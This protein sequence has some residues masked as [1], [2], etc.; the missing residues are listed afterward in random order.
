MAHHTAQT[1]YLWPLAAAAAT[2][3]LAGYFHSRALKLIDIDGPIEFIQNWQTRTELAASAGFSWVVACIAG[4]SGSS[5]LGVLT[6]G[7]L[8]SAA[9]IVIRAVRRSYD[10][11]RTVQAKSARVDH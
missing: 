5:F 10:E 7:M 8:L 6:I 4:L 3:V 1:L 2:M 11:H 9:P